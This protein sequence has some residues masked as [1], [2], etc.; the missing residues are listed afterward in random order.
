MR[1]TLKPDVALADKL[2]C[3]FV[4]ERDGYRC[5]S[6]GRDE[7][8]RYLEW[9]HI[10][11]RGARYLRWEPS[12]AVALCHADHVYFTDHPVQ[13]RRF[14][15]EQFGPDHMDRLHILQAQAEARGDR[16][17]VAQVIAFFRER[18]TPSESDRYWRGDW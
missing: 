8:T 13:W 17:D 14:I 9:C 7:R 1:S 6:C 5:Q 16:V 18:L 10:L 11:T 4:L 3:E 15:A 12:N 2:A